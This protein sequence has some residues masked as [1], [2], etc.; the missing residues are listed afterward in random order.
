MPRLRPELHA[1]PAL[2]NARVVRPSQTPGFPSAGSLAGLGPRGFLKEEQ[3]VP[4][5]ARLTLRPRLMRAH[6]RPARPHPNLPG[7][8]S[9]HA[10]AQA[11]LGRGFAAS[12]PRC[13]GLAPEPDA[14]MVCPPCRARR[15]D[16]G[17]RLPCWPVAAAAAPA[18]SGASQHHS[19]ANTSAYGSSVQIVNG[20]CQ[21]R[22][23]TLRV[24]NVTAACHPGIA[25]SAISGTQGQGLQHSP[26]AAPGAGSSAIALARHDIVWP[27]RV[28]AAGE[29]LTPWLRVSRERRRLRRS[30]T[31][32]G[33]GYQ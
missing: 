1:H 4:G 11:A 3:G 27:S 14:W 10:P 16:C 19:T 25:R 2:G 5:C 26:L 6:E 20:W 13:L 28:G 31:G 15:S 21:T 23:Q 24:R 8:L 12:G 9:G 22:H 32:P 17:P 33:M 30:D 18:I 29:R 7:R